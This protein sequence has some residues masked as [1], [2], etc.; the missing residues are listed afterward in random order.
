MYGIQ[1]LGTLGGEFSESQATGINDSGVVVG[2]SE[3]V[4]FQR[5]AFVWTADSGMQDLGTLGGSSST[6]IA[7]NNA[8]VIVGTS[9]TATGEGRVCLWRPAKQHLT[10]H[11][12]KSL[13]DSKRD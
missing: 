12:K 11:N 13:A 2:W 4:N 9:D 5:H 3:T 7:I 6:A 8:G 10:L 1:D